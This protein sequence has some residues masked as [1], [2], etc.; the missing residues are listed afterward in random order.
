MYSPRAAPASPVADSA[1]DGR[2]TCAWLHARNTN[3]D[4]LAVRRRLTMTPRLMS[5]TDPD[6]DAAGF[7]FLDL[8]VS[9]G[10]VRAQRSAESDAA[11]YIPAPFLDGVA[12]RFGEEEPARAV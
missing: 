5:E 1:S 6:G 12:I 4:T 2:G 3:K 8:V 7:V 11:V 9:G 10:D